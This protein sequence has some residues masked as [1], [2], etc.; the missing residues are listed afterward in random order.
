MASTVAPKLLMFD[1]RPFCDWVIFVNSDPDLYPKLLPPES[2]NLEGVYSTKGRMDGMIYDRFTL[3][4]KDTEIGLAMVTIWPS[5]RIEA[6]FD[7]PGCMTVVPHARQI[8]VDL[9]CNIRRNRDGVMI[10]PWSYEE[11]L[12]HANPKSPPDPRPAPWVKAR[13]PGLI[14]EDGTA[15]SWLA[16]LIRRQFIEYGE[17][18]CDACIPDNWLVGLEQIVPARKELTRHGF[19]T[20]QRGRCVEC[21]ESR[22]LSFLVEGK[23]EYQIHY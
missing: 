2:M 9:R 19:V 10:H 21:G 13:E 16:T 1:R 4:A 14:A 22:M 6:S 7:A 8:H 23:H 12:A 11:E 20:R 18:R 15:L 17:G 5:G 3:Y